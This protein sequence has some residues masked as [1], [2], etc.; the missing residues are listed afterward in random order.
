[1]TS[2]SSSSNGEP[3][4]REEQ[5][6]LPSFD[7][8]MRKMRQTNNYVL[9]LDALLEYGFAQ[10][11]LTYPDGNSELQSIIPISIQRTLKALADCVGDLQEKELKWQNLELYTYDTFDVKSH[12]ETSFTALQNDS[13]FEHWLI[14]FKAKL[15]ANDIDTNTFLDS[16]WPPSNIVGF[17]C[18]FYVKQCAFFWVLMLQ[19]FKSNLSSSCVLSH[20]SKCNGLQAY[21][22]FIN[23]H[24]RSKSKESKVKFITHWFDELEHLNKLRPPTRPLEYKTIKTALCQACVTSFQLVSIQFFKVTDSL[25]FNDVSVFIQAEVNVIHDLKTTL[26]LEATRLDSQALLSISRSNVRAHV[27]N[28]SVKDSISSTGTED[29]NDYSLPIDFDWQISRL[30]NI[31]SWRNIRSHNKVTHCHL[32]N[33]SR[34]AMKGWLNVP[35]DDKKK[36]IACLKPELLSEQ[37]PN[38]NVTKPINRRAYTHDQSVTLYDNATTTD[39]SASKSPSEDLHPARCHKKFQQRRDIDPNLSQRL[40]LQLL[41][42]TMFLKQLPQNF[43]PVHQNLTRDKFEFKV[44]QFPRQI[45]KKTDKLIKG[46]TTILVDDSIHQSVPGFISY[47][48][49][50]QQKLHQQILMEHIPYIFCEIFVT[51]PEALCTNCVDEGLSTLTLYSYLPENRNKI[52]LLTPSLAKK[53]LEQGEDLLKVNLEV[54]F[55]SRTQA[56]NTKGNDLCLSGVFKHLKGSNFLYCTLPD[57]L[58]EGDLKPFLHHFKTGFDALCSINGHLV[59]TILDRCKQTDAV[60]TRLN[61]SKEQCGKEETLSIWEEAVKYVSE[62]VFLDH[63]EGGTVAMDHIWAMGIILPYLLWAYPA[64]K[65]TENRNC[66][67]NIIIG[68]EELQE[69][70]RLEQDGHDC[71]CGRNG[72]LVL[73]IL[74]GC[75]E[76][77]TVRTRLNS[78]KGQFDNKEASSI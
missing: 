12:D 20:S 62:E 27:H 65:G 44:N 69:Q 78:R 34:S 2:P 40:H 68:P 53:L 42:K 46:S 33:L 58:Q 47:D 48:M 31:Q 16:S 25:D 49:N 23:L 71:L 18:D 74:D 41:P 75:K 51:D 36:L 56:H 22:D 11:E 50:Y 3:E 66:Y 39:T 24:S 57:L 76:T 32:E 43:L 19:V 10:Q 54:V 73:R 67:N 77:N 1:M 21:F 35:A 6:N 45:D 37:Q 60:R 14:G 7:E 70:K 30:C 13:R 52:I 63:E 5:I 29:S 9:F 72:H 15:K 8:S 26:L 17:K 61:S 59:L 64:L 28:L 55:L 4:T 38:P